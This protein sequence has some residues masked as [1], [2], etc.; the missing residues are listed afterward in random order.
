[1]TFII[2]PAILQN[3]ITTRCNLI[4]IRDIRPATL[5]DEGNNNKKKKHYEKGLDV[6]GSREIMI[7]RLEQQLAIEDTSTYNYEE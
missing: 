6:D 7:A 5:K 2:C 4:L 3:L 1:M